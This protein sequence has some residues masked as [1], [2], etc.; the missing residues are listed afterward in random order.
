MIIF[1]LRESHVAA[2]PM[3]GAS[4][5]T[6]E[7]KA[8]VGLTRYPYFHLYWLPLVPLP[9]TALAVCAHCRGVREVTKTAQGVTRPLWHW[10]L[11]GCLANAVVCG[12]IT[13]AASGI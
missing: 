12:V 13:H 9:S 7:Q 10:L 1:G 6:C 2:G 3:Q 5:P 11:P 4:C 8:L